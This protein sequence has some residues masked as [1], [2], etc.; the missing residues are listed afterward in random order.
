MEFSLCTLIAVVIL[1]LFQELCVLNKT[2]VLNGEET[3]FPHILLFFSG[4]SDACVSCFH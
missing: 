4:K 1:Q 2:M 3:S